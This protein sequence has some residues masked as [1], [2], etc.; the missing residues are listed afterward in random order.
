[1]PKRWTIQAGVIALGAVVAVGT[2]ERGHYVAKAPLVRQVAAGDSAARAKM[3]SLLAGAAPTRVATAGGLDNNVE[4]PRV[5]YWVNRLSTSMGG[6]FKTSLQRMTKYADM[7]TRKLEARDMPTD[8]AYLALI[9][10]NFNPNARSRVQ[11]VGMWQFMKGTA[12]DYGLAVGKRVDERKD[13]VRATD[14][15]VKYLDELHGRLGSWYLAAAAYNSGEG[16]VR[17]AMRKVLGRTE[18][19]DDDFFRIMHELPK[20]T[21]DY[22]PK[23]IAAARIGNDPGKYGLNVDRTT[24]VAEAAPAP[25]AVKQ[26]KAVKK[27]KTAK[28]AR[29]ARTATKSKTTGRKS[30]VTKR[31]KTTKRPA[32]APLH[33]KAAQ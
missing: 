18:G 10:S 3:N 15:A 32:T 31:P 7:I 16:T 23:L 9:E 14:A 29:S 30:V 13:P 5:D 12:K 1:M 8:L 19:T 4:H 24:A 33:R 6:G 2:L 21:Q 11:A 22:V 25:V 17:K 28:P 27:V 20:E 26:A